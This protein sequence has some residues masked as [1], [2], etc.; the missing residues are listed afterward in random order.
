METYAQALAARKSQ[1]AAY[2]EAGYATSRSGPSALAKDPRIVAR[3]DEIMRE[4]ETV[5]S[6]GMLTAIVE[7]GI[8][9]GYVLQRLQENVE[10]AMTIIAVRDEE[11]QPTGEYR[12]DGA[13][14]NRALE[15]LG[16]E[17]G[18]FVDRQEISITDLRSMDAAGLVRLLGEIDRALGNGGDV[19]GLLAA[20]AVIDV[21]PEPAAPRPPK[22][23]VRITGI[24]PGPASLAVSFVL[25][26]SAPQDVVSSDRESGI[27][28][29][30]DAASAGVLLPSDAEVPG[31][32]SP[33]PGP[34]SP[35]GDTTDLPDSVSLDI[36]LDAGRTWA[37]RSPDS[38]DSPL[39]L[40]DLRGATVYRIAL[41]VVRNGVPSIPSRVMS[42]R[43]EPTGPPTPLMVRDPMSP[44]A[45]RAAARRAKSGR[46]PETPEARATRLRAIGFKRAPAAAPI[47]SDPD[48]SDKAPIQGQTD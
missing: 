42:A 36:S 38:I 17:L 44:D 4:R 16:K 33:A 28:P 21:V 3:V 34:P 26:V 30:D 48:S 27:L 37:P 45:V 46:V 1:V 39:V 40:A 12:Y 41:R 23:S 2:A 20:P 32:S 15:L 18:M 9:K 7:T 25:P 31:A 19:A 35:D 22:P 5:A 24:V 11:G 14:A 10:R 47:P 43:T 6:R 13:V 8:S 29:P